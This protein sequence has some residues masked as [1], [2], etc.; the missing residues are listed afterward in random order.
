MNTELHREI[1]HG[2]LPLCFKLNSDDV[3]GIHPPEPYFMMASRITYFPLVIDRVVKYFNRFVDQTRDITENMWLD[4]DGQ[5]IKWDYP[6]GLSWDLHGTR[7]DLP[8]RLILHFSNFPSQEISRCN[9]K[10][11]IESNFM[12]TIKEADFLKHKGAVMRNL[13]KKECNQLWSGLVNDKFDQF[14]QV[15]RRLMDKCD[16]ELFKSIPFRLYLP[17]CSYIQKIV[18]PLTTESSMFTK[19]E[20]ATITR[21]PYLIPESGQYSEQ[22]EVIKCVQILSE[23]TGR[24][25]ETSPRWT[26]LLD[27][28]QISFKYRM[29]EILNDNVDLDNDKLIDASKLKYRFLTHGIEI[30]HDAPL[31]W[32][33]ENLSYPDNF[34]NICAVPKD[35]QVLSS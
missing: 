26:T 29:Q 14:W 25:T 16:N 30:P 19:S 5:P 23:D 1:W 35:H 27:L 11:S 22:T 10:T 34:L 9:T 17:D 18:K 2:R 24:I 33:S 13:V 32:L 3:I 4:F 6:I 28:I 15:N 7:E 12:S 21:G 31:Q 20:K 8:W